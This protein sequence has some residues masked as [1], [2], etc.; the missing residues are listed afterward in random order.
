MR[1]PVELLLI[2]LLCEGHAL[3]ED[4]PGTGKTRLAQALARLSALTFRRVQFTPDL[5]PSD[6]LG[7]AVFDPRSAEFRFREGPIFTHVLLADE[8]NRA[9]PRTQAA[10]LEAMEERQVSADGETRPLPRPFLVLATQ[11]PVDMEGTFPLPEAQLDRFFVRVT[12]GYPSDAGELE[13]LLRV[14]RR[15]AAEDVLARLQPVASGEDLA[16]FIE[17]VR[18]VAVAPEVAQYAVHLVR[19]TRHRPEVDVGASPR[20]AVALYRAPPARGGPRCPPPRLA[21]RG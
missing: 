15:E 7:T 2:A 18:D 4:V 8:I 14:G 19:A 11:N 13:M 5:M 1:R 3:L 10:L 12:V 16:G 17:A 6:I 21:G 9:T 20:A